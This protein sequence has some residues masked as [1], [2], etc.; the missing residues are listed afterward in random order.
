M[1]KIAE[2]ILANHAVSNILTRSEE[3]SSLELNFLGALQL[4]FRRTIRQKRDLDRWFAFFKQ[5][6]DLV[7]SVVG[8]VDPK[9]SLPDSAFDRRAENGKIGHSYEN[10]IAALNDGGFQSRLNAIGAL[11]KMGDARATGPLIVMLGHEQAMIR[12]EAVRALGMIGDKRAVNA[13]A[14][15]LDDE[16]NVCREAANAL[17]RI[18]SMLAARP[19][20]EI[21]NLMR[22]SQIFMRTTISISNEPRNEARMAIIN[23][24]ESIFQTNGEFLERFPR[25]FCSKCLRQA[26]KIRIPKGAFQN[27]EYTVCPECNDTDYLLTGAEQ[28][29]GVVGGLGD[30]LVEDG[31]TVFVRLWFDKEK[32]TRYADIDRLEVRAGGVTH[33]EQAVNA[34]ILELTNDANRP[35]S[36]TRK[37]SVRKEGNPP[38]SEAALQMLK[39]NFEF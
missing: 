34:L 7:N 9:V 37:I 29:V 26:V 16:L 28:I 33:Y 19:L 6:I 22:L 24:L 30:D 10:L 5:I 27:V 21:E 36:S 18:G 8:T 38:L 12:E 1:P 20:L 15:A 4:R 2:R 11:G 14:A 23:A 32:R 3:I 13:L 17:G 35:A 25:L 39:E 31:G